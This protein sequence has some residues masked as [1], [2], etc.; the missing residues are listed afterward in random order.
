MRRPLVPFGLAAGLYVVLTIALTWPLVLHPGSRVPNDLGDSLLNMF[1][2]AWNAR[3][4]PLT[5][6]WWNLPQFYPLPGMMAL[7]E[8]LLGLWP[9]TTPVIL[10]TGNAVLAYNIAF[11]LSFPLCAMAAH[12]LVFELTRRHD[13]A[14]IAGLA[15]GFAPY[16]MLQLAHI[17]VLSSYW[18]PVALLGLH[19]Y[20][21]T[22]RFRWAALFAIAWLFQALACGYY[23]FYLS[24]LIGLWL[25]WF[26]VGRIRWRDLGT[27]VGAWTAAVI[28]IVPIGLGYLKYQQAYGL[29]RWPNEIEI[30]SADA[31]SLL[32]APGNLRLWGWLKVI[33]RP[34]A[35][36]FPGLTIV[37]L[38]VAGAVIAW[39]A[40]AHP[41][42]A[43]L[44][45][46]R[47]LLVSAAVFALMAATP[48]WVGPWKLEVAGMRLLSVG[49][50]HKPLT[51][52]L[53]LAI[54]A[55]AMHPSMRI[56]WRQR[57]P[58]AFY[59]VGAG[60][61]WLFSLGPSPT[62]MNAPLIYKAPYSWLLKVPGVDGVRVPA[63]FWVLATACLAIAAGLAYA[64]IT[65]R[66]T[67]LRRILPVA[68]AALILLEAWP[69]P[70]ALEAVPTARP[71]HARAVARLELPVSSG[72]DLLVLY[73]ASLHRRPVFNGYSG[74][75]APHYAALQYLLARRD[76]DALAV[77]TSSGPVEVIVDHDQDPD[78]IWRRFIRRYPDNDVVHQDASYSAY[79]LP[80]TRTPP[81]LPAFALPRLPI[82]SVR[83]SHHAD[84]VSYML[85]GVRVTRWDTG[86]PQD[87]SNEVII[88]LGTSR[89][90]EGIE[91]RLGGFVADFPR[92]LTIDLSVDGATWNDVWSDSAALVTL[93]AA[94]DDPLN[95]PLRFPLGGA[96][97][98]Y[99][100]LR[101]RGSDPLYYWS[102][103]E[104]A[105]H[106]R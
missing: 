23:L 3:E 67:T 33:D 92:D 11:F 85:D 98:R 69:H 42:M 59:A 93:M 31:A 62:L 15:Y 37:L 66:W 106:G 12:L 78:E 88:D 35:D 13:A 26:A 63:R 75:F 24:V 47:I 71:V 27:L 9:L 74:Y 94:L 22:G 80:R 79:L 53:V 34:E 4:T 1:I 14:L 48:L 70:L 90:L 49:T 65:T 29:R 77:L 38:I 76:R 89:H 84:R 58:L 81:S 2:L 55:F 61:M 43:R 44:R 87:P 97:A 54:V 56:G 50:P 99:V 28:A 64:R 101:Q 103:A 30:F 17:Q 96:S 95:V 20:V 18:T 102:I 86:A 68:T 19:K 73:R 41:A 32:S 104:L 105:I 46:P 83:A 8:H 100:R 51:L 91:T 82:A 57:S 6:S 52:A 45:M 5:T 72:N 7:S 10:T 21:R 25:A 16:R 60:V 36:L 40:A 39:A